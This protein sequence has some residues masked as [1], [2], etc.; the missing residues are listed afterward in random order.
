[1]QTS[2]ER[3]QRDLFAWIR[4]KFGAHADAFIH[5]PNGGY[6]HKSQAARLKAAGV[7]RGVPDV[8]FF[9]RRGG[10]TGLAIELKTAKGRVSPEQSV[11]LTRLGSEGWFATVAFGIDS[12]QDTIAGYMALPRDTG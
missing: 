9:E 11:W 1:M 8:L 3:M 6:R 10:F 7:R 5:V 2:E 12:A 4:L